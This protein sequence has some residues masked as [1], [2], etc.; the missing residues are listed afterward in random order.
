MNRRTAT[1]VRTLMATLT[2]LVLAGCVTVNGGAVE[3]SWTV[4]TS[5]GKQ[6]A[7]QNDDGSDPIGDIWLCAKAC[8][9]ISNGACVG[10]TTCPVGKW[11]CDRTHGSTA[12]EVTAGRKQL[13]IQ[14][15]CPNGMPANVIVPEPIIH[16][17]ADGEV[18]QLNAVLITKPAGGTACS[19]T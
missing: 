15:F 5:D 12:F 10:D 14:V 11:A 8:T 13:W 3:L 17:V 1:A 2:G 18:T 4:R 6:A 19:T 7:C 16:D 9:V